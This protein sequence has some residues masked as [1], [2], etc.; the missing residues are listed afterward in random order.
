METKMI[1][2]LVSGMYSS[3][4]H[5]HMSWVPNTRCVRQVQIMEM[6][7][8]GLNYMKLLIFNCNLP[9]EGQVHN[10]K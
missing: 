10:S 4:F 2:K 9:T 6:K 7:P 3:C 5:A 8:L 1:L